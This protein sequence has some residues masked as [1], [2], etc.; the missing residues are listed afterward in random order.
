[1]II[2]LDGKEFKKIK[3]M[4]YRKLNHIKQSNFLL[5]KRMILKRNIFEQK[6]IISG[7]TE[8]IKNKIINSVED[9]PNFTFDMLKDVHGHFNKQNNHFNFSIEHLGNSHNISLDI[10]ASLSKHDDNS[11]DISTLSV[12]HSTFDIGVKIPIQN[13][14]VKHVKH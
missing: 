5:E 6:V 1:M 10:G 7:D 12:P 13:L 3:I 4:T 2:T 8:F 14:F 9:I 11:H